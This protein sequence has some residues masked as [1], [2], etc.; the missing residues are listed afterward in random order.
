MAAPQIGASPEGRRSVDL[1]APAYSE[2][3]LGR[4]RAAFPG[5]S[6]TVEVTRSRE[7]FYPGLFGPAPR[8]DSIYRALAAFVRD[9][10]VVDIGS[11]SGAGLAVLSA[12]RSR[13][14]VDVSE[15]AHRFATRATPGVTFL[16]LDA[17]QAELPPADVVTIVDVLGCAHDPA[18]LL[19]AAARS[20]G[21]SGTL[22]VAEPRASIA[23]ELLPPARA[24]FS[25]QGLAVL[26]A[27]AG[28]ELEAWLSEGR[29][30][31]VRARRVPNI[32]AERL[33]LARSQLRASDVNRALEILSQPPPEPGGLLEASWAL[34]SAEAHRLRG[35]GD[36]ALTALIRGHEQAPDEARLLARLAEVLIDSGEREQAERFASAAV[37]RD[38][39]SAE[40][41]RARARALTVSATPEERVGLWQRAL[42]LDPS[43]MDLSVRLAIAASE[44]GCYSIGMTALEKVREYGGNLPADFHLTLGWLRLMVGRLEEALVECRWAQLIEPNHPGV[45]D[46]QLAIC[47]SDPKPLGQ[48]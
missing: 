7:R 36:A 22:Y 41:V 11:G 40:A 29:F 30:W 16:C 14:G 46:L 17:A 28:F 39:A 2:L 45:M 34:L 5:D 48:C 12:A 35:D 3:T 44:V 33:E 23:Q 8:T 1:V 42:R 31:V 38:P 37:D 15:E 20:L 47:E 13:V 6:T 25:K 43:N 21:A 18:A 24:A 10:N 4:F 9:Q 27:E 26:L 19:R 32:W